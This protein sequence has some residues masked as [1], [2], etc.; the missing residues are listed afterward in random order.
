MLKEFTLDP[1]TKPAPKKLSGACS[2]HHSR[3]ASGMP[4]TGKRNRKGERHGQAILTWADGS[5][6]TGEY[7]DGMPVP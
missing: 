5:T 7:K 1:R 4:Y 2:L 6:Y 3:Q